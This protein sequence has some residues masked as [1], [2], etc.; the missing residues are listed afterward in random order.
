[1]DC[2]N[3]E[4]E[5]IDRLMDLAEEGLSQANNLLEHLSLKGDNSQKFLDILARARFL[6][7]HLASLEEQKQ[8]INA[9]R[10]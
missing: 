7:A 9:F 8:I 4:L 6:K 5:D 2:S 3:K 10:S 1:M